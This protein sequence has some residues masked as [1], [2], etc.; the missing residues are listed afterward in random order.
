MEKKANHPKSILKATVRPGSSDL[1]Q[2][3]GNL[4]KLCNH[5]MS[6]TTY[7]KGQRE[8]MYPKVSRRYFQS[9]Q[10]QIQK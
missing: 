7:E 5:F 8:A 6:K 10:N 4:R 3:I 1:M 9:N 2:K